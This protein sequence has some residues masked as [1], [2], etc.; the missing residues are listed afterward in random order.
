ML[1]ERNCLTD[2]RKAIFV[3]LR[4]M[5]LS[6]NL[7]GFTLTELLVVLVIVGVLVLLALPRFLPLTTRAKSTEAKIQLKYLSELQKVYF[8]EFS[9]YSS[10]IDDIGFEVPTLIEDGG[11][12]RYA[13]EIVEAGQSSFIARATSTEDYDG[14]GIYNVWEV[15]NDMPPK[16]IVKD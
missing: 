3:Y 1:S 14:D 5:L 2:L 6:L 9:Q 13:I 12:A 7:K 11:E 15:R 4:D 8:L 10:S 16:E